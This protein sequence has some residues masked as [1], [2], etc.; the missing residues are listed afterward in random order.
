MLENAFYFYKHKDRNFSFSC[1]C[2]AKGLA[3]RE[4]F[5]D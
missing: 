1:A 4:V 3:K 5:G 2:V